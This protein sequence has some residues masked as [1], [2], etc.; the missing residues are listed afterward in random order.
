MASSF[1]DI[2]QSTAEDV[3]LKAKSHRSPQGW[4]VSAEV[5]DK[6]YAAWIEGEKARREL[7]AEPSSAS[8]RRALKRAMETLTRITAEAVKGFLEEYVQQLE[9]HIRKGRDEEGGL[10]RDMGHVRARW[11]GWFHT[12]R[13]HQILQSLFG[14]HR[15]AQ[16]VASMPDIGSCTLGDR[17]GGGSSVHGK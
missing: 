7:R 5:K 6:L 3:A 10:L 12:L 13:Q 1:A 15:P 16:G 2:L 11:A 9:A 8:R 17:D 4:Y 14:S